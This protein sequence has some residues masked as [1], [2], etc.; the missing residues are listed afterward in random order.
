MHP[1]GIQCKTGTANKVIGK[2]GAHKKQI[3]VF[4]VCVVVVVFCFFW[5]GPFSYICTFHSAREA[6]PV[7]KDDEWQFFPTKV[8]DGL[9]CLVGRVRKPHLASLLDHLHNTQDSARLLLLMFVH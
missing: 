6:T 2:S 3:A 1:R 8:F 7:G 4:F 9:R 5:G